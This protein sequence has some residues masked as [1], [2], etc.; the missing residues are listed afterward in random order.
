MPFGMKNGNFGN[1]LV[2]KKVKKSLKLNLDLTLPH[3]I[4]ISDNSGP[5]DPILGKNCMESCT[6]LKQNINLTNHTPHEIEIS[7][8]STP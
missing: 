3:D 4:E 6:V 5:K 7:E 2:L 1:K 8:S